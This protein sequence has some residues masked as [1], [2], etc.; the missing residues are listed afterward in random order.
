MTT[1]ATDAPDIA[2]IVKGLEKEGYIV[3]TND[4]DKAY[5][6]KKEGEVIGTRLSDWATK[7]HQ[8]RTQTERKGDGLPRPGRQ[9]GQRG[10]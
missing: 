7:T 6:E 4:E 3:R 9:D 2:M 8:G 5:W 10:A 1:T